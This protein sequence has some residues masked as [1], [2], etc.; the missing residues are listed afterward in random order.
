M[1]AATGTGS[2]FHRK[3]LVLPPEPWLGQ[4]YSAARSPR[5]RVAA[6]R[7]WQSEMLAQRVPSVLRAEQ[8]SPLKFRHDQFNEIVQTTPAPAGSSA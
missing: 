5:A 7:P 2:F 8:P 3:R 1:R 6:G 4:F